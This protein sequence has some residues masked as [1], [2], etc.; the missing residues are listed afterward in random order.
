MESNVVVAA[1]VV[2]VVVAV[3]VVPP[4]N[5]HVSG[6]ANPAWTEISM[7]KHKEPLWACVQEVGTVRSPKKL[8]V[9]R[10]W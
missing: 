8:H 6:R 5:M 3:V 4:S 10:T 9:N 2:V 7:N 1:V